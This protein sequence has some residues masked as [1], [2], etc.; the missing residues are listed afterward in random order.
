MLADRAP[1]PLPRAD[2]AAGARDGRVAENSMEQNL[3]W[4]DCGVQTLL[5]LRPENGPVPALPEAPILN[6]SVHF[7][8]DTNTLLSPECLSWLSL[9]EVGLFLAAQR[10]LSGAFT[11]GISRCLISPQG[12]TAPRE[13]SFDSMQKPARG[14]EVAEL[15]SVLMLFHS[16]QT[17]FDGTALWGPPTVLN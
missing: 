5:T 1:A 13:P 6:S 14:H 7:R 11:Y 12:S 2:R 16:V 8:R 3:T 9:S 10:A 15:G 4:G 17:V